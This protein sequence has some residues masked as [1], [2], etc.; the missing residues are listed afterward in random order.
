MDAEEYRDKIDRAIGDMSGA[1]ILNGSHAHASII[2]ERMFAHAQNC[3]LIL[4]RK[5]DPRIYGAAE[6]VEQA[7]LYLGEADR[8]CRILVEEFDQASFENHPFVQRLSPYMEAGNLEV[9]TLDPRI[10]E[11]VNVNFSVM[12][13]C[14]YRFEEDKK[15]AV[16]VA[17]FG[18]GTESFVSSL[19]DLFSSLWERGSPVVVEGARELS[20][21]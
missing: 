3:V 12:D 7:G 16:A 11:I 1:T 9:R 6:A 8:K 17:S 21:G 14:G 13:Q 5:F 20:D 15:E 18:A 19:Q 2:I 10:A 4:T